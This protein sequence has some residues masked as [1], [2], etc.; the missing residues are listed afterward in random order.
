MKKL[1][2][3]SVR[4]FCLIFCL[5]YSL[6]SNAQQS[7]C[8]DDSKVISHVVSNYRVEDGLA[9]NTIKDMMVDEADFLWLTTEKGLSRFDGISFKNFQKSPFRNGYDRMNLIYKF[10]DRLLFENRAYISVSNGHT[11]ID[12]TQNNFEDYFIG[13][14][15]QYIKRSAFPPG[16][17]GSFIAHND[18]WAHF[19]IANDSCIYVAD[20]LLENFSCYQNG[21]KLGEID[22]INHD[23]YEFPDQYFVKDGQFFSV[24][25]GILRGYNG[26]RISDSLSLEALGSE[27]D[28]FWKHQSDNVFIR[29]QATGSIYRFVKKN[30]S[31]C[32][33]LIIGDFGNIPINGIM[34]SRSKGDF[35]IGSRHE[36]LYFLK[37]RVFATWQSL[38]TEKNACVSITQVGKDS[39]LTDQNIILTPTT[40]HSLNLE[41][42]PQHLD[43]LSKAKNPFY[44][45]YKQRRFLR[46]T[47]SA[48]K[49][50]LSSPFVMA[51][52]IEDNNEQLWATIDS[53]L[54]YRHNGKWKQKD[55]KEIDE[56]KHEAKTILFNP[57]TKKIWISFNGPFALY[58]YQPGEDYC[59]KVDNLPDAEILEIF[60]TPDGMAWIRFTD[61]GF[62][63]YKNGKFVP[64]PYDPNNYLQFAHCIRED[65]NGFF[66]ISTDQGL[67]KVL[68][69]DLLEYFEK[70]NQKRVYYHYYD[71]SWGFLNNEFNGRGFP[72]GINLSDGKIAFPSF[73][74]VVVF[75]PTEVNEPLQGNSISIDNIRIDRKDTVLKPKITL[76]Q[77]FKEL[78]FSISHFYMGHPNNIYIDF[79]LE[80]YH[81]DWLSLSETGKITFSSLPF[82]NYTLLVRKLTGSGLNNLATTS[83]AFT[84]KKQIYETWL[85][86]VSMFLCFAVLIIILFAT[87]SRLSKQRQR[88]LENIID[89]KTKEY[90]AL[91]E[92]LKLNMAR[93]RITEEEQRK[94]NKLR[95]RMMAIYTHDISGPLRFIMTVA[96]KIAEPNESVKARGISSYLNAIHSTTEKIFQQTEHMFKL[97][98]IEDEQF[99]FVLEELDLKSVVNEIIAGSHEQAAEKNISLVNNVSEDCKI[100]IEKNILEISINN[101]L[102]NAIKFT[103]SGSITFKDSEVDN[104]CVLNISDTGIGMTKEQL[105][106]FKEGK[107]RSTDGTQNE[108]GSGF[109]LKVVKDLLKKLNAYME[110]ESEANGGT[111]VS[112]FFKKEKPSSPS[113]KGIDLFLTQDPGREDTLS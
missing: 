3:E 6:S 110:I 45:L 8:I 98:Y 56:I 53:D 79:K 2:S 35:W 1:F 52:Y 29:S 89:D 25:E 102:Q 16:N 101:I 11:F 9:Q 112:F 59:T 68:K 34:E 87:R 111:T 69:Q 39:I 84:V 67:F 63:M 74:G 86:K 50:T 32:L 99:D 83:L 15:S 26:P 71:K 72:C 103:N 105:K 41:H 54:Y 109:G 76:N 88:N 113:Q 40:S 33:E 31:F 30:E 97:S 46:N 95:N 85:F 77:D 48:L 12:S 78:E 44:L 43:I 106:K 18:Y 49:D 42:S 66:W 64:I 20:R 5:I 22:I 51:S 36:G 81:Q 7:I 80:G 55:L 27:I 14:Y 100:Y 70:P 96:Q 60:F 13:M 47:K 94:S 65:E 90:L 108:K 37:K 10:D 92:Q 58:I 107:S 61:L 73:A 93:L 21:I 57:F 23:L 104:Y 28:I 91:N 17:L 75:D 19:I 82:G 38:D 4:L 62:Y 24:H